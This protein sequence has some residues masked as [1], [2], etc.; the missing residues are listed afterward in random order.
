VGASTD[1]DVRQAVVFPPGTA[2]GL[3]ERNADRR[4]LLLQVSFV[5]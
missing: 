1:L 4:E 5:G 3:L 2:F